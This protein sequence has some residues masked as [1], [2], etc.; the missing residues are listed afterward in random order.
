MPSSLKKM[1]KGKR[2][3]VL[4]TLAVFFILACCQAAQNSVTITTASG[5]ALQ[6]QVEIA[7]TPEERATGLMFRESLPEGTGMLFVFSGETQG[8]FWMK[9]TPIPL[10]MI[11]AKEGRVVDII[12]N[13]TPYSEELLTPGA[14]YDMVLEVSG[15]YAGRNG[16]QSGDAFSS[17]GAS[18]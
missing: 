4:L 17:L 3:P 15:G 9:N 5:Q 13:A 10:D 16:V 11:F 12:E 8:S 7:D 2:F 1:K 18:P 6:V 14:S